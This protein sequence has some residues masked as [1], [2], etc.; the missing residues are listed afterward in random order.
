MGKLEN[1]KQMT[2]GLMDLHYGVN[3][4]EVAKESF[5]A[6]LSFA[7]ISNLICNDRLSS[8]N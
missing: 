8:T 7:I 3:R 6:N 2:V 4:L 1:L 5:K